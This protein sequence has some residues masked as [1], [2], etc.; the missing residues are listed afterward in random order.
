MRVFAAIDLPEQ[1][2]E[3]IFSLSRRFER[4][5]VKRVKKENLH[6]T[7]AFFGEIEKGQEE[8]LEEELMGRVDVGEIELRLNKLEIFPNRKKAFGVWIAVEGDLEKLKTLY[9]KVVEAGLRAGIELEEK[10]LKFSPHVT[11]AR[12]KKP[13][14]LAEKELEIGDLKGEKIK[15]ESVVLFESKLSSDG[16]TYTKIKEFEVK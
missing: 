10:R 3:K 5:G 16:P 7:L 2:K 13:L 8:R 9:R 1:L 4:P 11:L 6:L 14:K 15:V 12:F